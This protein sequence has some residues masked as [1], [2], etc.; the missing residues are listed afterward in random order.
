MI[1]VSGAP[2]E[3]AEFRLTSLEVVFQNR[4]IVLDPVIPSKGIACAMK[5]SDDPNCLAYDFDQ[6][7]KCTLMTKINH[8]NLGT[9]KK[10]FGK[11][12]GKNSCAHVNT[13]FKSHIQKKTLLIY[14][15]SIFFVTALA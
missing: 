8:G 2:M 11:I 9:P 5:C 13:L 6:I 12:K 14:L 15:Y 1:T 7:S 10:V 3:G 4:T